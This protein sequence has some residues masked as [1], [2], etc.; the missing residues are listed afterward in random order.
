[1]ANQQLIDYIKKSLSQNISKEAIKN[2]LLSRGWPEKEIELA[3][4]SVEGVK[5]Q[6]TES[7][8]TR[9]LSFKELWNK[10]VA[11]YKQRF[12]FLIAVALVPSLV[13]S[14][15]FWFAIRIIQNG[16][17]TLAHNVITLI[18]LFLIEILLG[19]FIDIS[20]LYAIKEPSEKSL[21]SVYRKGWA[22]FFSF[23]VIRLL[24]ISISLAPALV[25]LFCG[26]SSKEMGFLPFYSIASGTL[27]LIPGLIFF[28]YF[29]F[30]EF[31]LVYENKRGINALMRSKFYTSG[32]INKEIFPRIISL[33]FCLILLML[34]VNF[35]FIL[36]G[37]PV[38]ETIMQMINT[39]IIT[40]FR[41][42][43]IFFLYSNI[44][45][46]RGTAVFSVKQKSKTFF[47]VLAIIGVIFLV[48]IP[49]RLYSF[50]KEKTRAFQRI[51]SPVV[52]VEQ[53]SLK[54]GKISTAKAWRIPFE[55]PTH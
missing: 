14:P 4:Q 3:F 19:W 26:L 42:V 44:R 33:G 35:V 2:A 50:L 18:I 11:F 22:N 55:I 17:L 8:P 43:F 32:L 48:M 37:I 20:L 51:L 6:V 52:S 7:P 28:L 53:K 24:V 15:F 16:T 12:L 45:A 30:A 34:A 5:S 31:I 49:F 25:V 47:L 54:V 39:A 46:L 36:M 27:A 21:L 38:R 23:S 41:L 1:M 10:T 9:L 40:P 13:A 29:I